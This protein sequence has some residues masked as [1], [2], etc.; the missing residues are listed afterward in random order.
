MLI[1]HQDGGE[2][3]G[4]LAQRR[5]RGR[6]R[7]VA[8]G[9]G[10]VRPTSEHIESVGVDEPTIV[11][12]NVDHHAIAGAVLLIEIEIKLRQRLLRHVANVHVAQP[13][14]ADLGHVGAIVLHPLAVNLVGQRRHRLH[15][16]LP[17]RNIEHHALIDLVL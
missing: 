5:A 6:R 3:Q 8:V 1:H 17:P 16:N 11:I 12:A 10:E 4:S 7:T 14:V 2:F 15:G 13:V 9:H